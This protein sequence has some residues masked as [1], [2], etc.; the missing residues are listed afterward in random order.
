MSVLPVARPPW[1]P[2]PA[3][4]LLLLGLGLPWAIFG[5]LLWAVLRPGGLAWDA[6]LLLYWHRH[7]TPVL[8]KLAVFLTIIGN[9]GPMVGTALLVLLGLLWRRQGRRAWVFLLSVGGSMVLTQV[10]KFWVMRPRPALWA[11]LRPEHTYSFPSGHA[12]DTAAVA[13][14][15]CFLAW[16][17]RSQWWVWALAPLFS[18]AVGWARMYLGVHHPSDV[19][20]GWSSAVGW[21]VLA[22]AV[23]SPEVQVLFLGVGRP[24]S[25]GALRAD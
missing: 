14:A 24:P 21:V 19:L 17:H 6:P 20:A 13:A 8:D 15:L 7:A 10:I 18:L 2:V 11:S 25:R 22:Q 12:M 1:R 9:T 16:R 5:S 4:F 23:A 3:A